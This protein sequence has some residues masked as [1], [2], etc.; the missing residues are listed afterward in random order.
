MPSKPGRR[1][2]SI[3]FGAGRTYYYTY[4]LLYSRRR[5]WG[6]RRYVISRFGF[7]NRKVDD[8]GCVETCILRC[9]DFPGLHFSLCGE[10]AVPSRSRED[11]LQGRSLPVLHVVIQFWD[12]DFGNL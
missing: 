9:P 12:V 4:P 8:G 3:L 1:P 5:S 11:Q 10:R 7:A 2:R 6:R